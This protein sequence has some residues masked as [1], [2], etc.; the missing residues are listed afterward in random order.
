MKYLK[1]FENV[2]PFEEDELEWSELTNNFFVGKI[3]GTKGRK[4][5]AINYEN[6]NKYVIAVGK[7]FIGGIATSFYKLDCD[8]LNDNDIEN[9]NNGEPILLWDGDNDEFVEYSKEE[10]MKLLKVDDLNF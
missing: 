10:L 2:D 8:E 4:Y 3:E 6:G 7:I 5:F 9:I 1:Y